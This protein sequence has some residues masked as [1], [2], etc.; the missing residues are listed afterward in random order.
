MKKCPFSHPRDDIDHHVC[1][2]MIDCGSCPNGG[3]CRFSHDMVRNEICEQ[4]SATGETCANWRKRLFSHPR[5][6]IDLHVCSMMRDTGSFLYGD[7]CR[8]SHE[9]VREEIF[10]QWSVT[11]SCASMKTCTLSRPKIC[12]RCLATGDLKMKISPCALP[13]QEALFLADDDESEKYEQ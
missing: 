9:V 5:E 4:W 12:D 3:E 8:F 2:T 10:E 1:F 7:E 6:D 13:A 11:A